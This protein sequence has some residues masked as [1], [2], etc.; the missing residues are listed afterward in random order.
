MVSTFDGETFLNQESTEAIDT[1]I[2]PI[3]I[4]DYQAQVDRINARQ[5]ST[6]EGDRIIL[7]IT[8]EVL[9]EDVKAELGL[10]K[11]TVRQSVFLDLTDEGAI[12]MSKGKNRQLGLVREAVGQN[13]NGKPWA[14]GNLV[15]Q[16]ATIKIEHRTDP[17][18]N[19]VVYSDVKR[20][21]AL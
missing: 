11:V 12:D 2:V 19:E 5:I 4:D 13:K 8:W 21:T 3:P 7:D 1:K 14:P 15:G 9:S 10:K 18:D 17:N 16:T 6:K 20:V